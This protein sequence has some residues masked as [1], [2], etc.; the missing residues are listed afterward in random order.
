MQSLK[1][2]TAIAFGVAALFLLCGSGH[3]LWWHY[4]AP[5]PIIAPLSSET[6][7]KARTL[8]DPES[9]REL[10]LIL[11]RQRQK[12]SELVERLLNSAVALTSITALLAAVALAGFASGVRAG[13]EEGPGDA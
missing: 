8:N 12:D 1:A 2:V 13:S 3:F 6:A 4:Y 7:E 10:A 11:S 9:L 5:R